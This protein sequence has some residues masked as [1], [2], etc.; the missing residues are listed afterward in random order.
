MKIVAAIALTLFLLRP[1]WAEDIVVIGKLLE[2]KPMAYV[3]R[4]CPESHICL[5]SWYESV[6]SVQKTIRGTN[7]SGRVSAAV[8]QHTSLNSRFKKSVRLFV[9][10]PI[11]DPAVRA[12]L[13]V[14]YYLKGMSEVR[15]MYCLGY[16]PKESGLDPETVYVSEADGHKS[17]CFELQQN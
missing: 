1:A 4:E 8:M 9:L 6:V 2:N 5:H 17:Y 7:L 10:K 3:P 16:D 13:R 14:D 12:K 11:E 15:Q